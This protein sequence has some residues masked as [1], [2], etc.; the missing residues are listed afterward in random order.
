[1]I[2]GEVNNCVISKGVYIGKGAKVSN[3]VIMQDTKIG[4]NAS[5]NYVICDKDVVVKDGRALMGYSSYPI[6]IA[7][8]SV[9]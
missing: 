9:V 1:M 3:C 8:A 7:K 5:L 4:E 2:E 6:Y